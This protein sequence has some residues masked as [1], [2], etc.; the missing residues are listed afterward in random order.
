MAGI[1][2]V[3][4]VGDSKFFATGGCDDLLGECV[5]D[6]YGFEFTFGQR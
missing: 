4:A 3:G 5:A 6:L 1:S 2:A